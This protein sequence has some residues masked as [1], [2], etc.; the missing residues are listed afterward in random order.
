MTTEAAAQLYEAQHL[1][2]NMDRTAAVYNPNNMS[3][4]DL[5]VI[6]G[7]NNG[8]SHG[9]YEAVLLA[10]DGTFMGDHI[11]TSEAYMPFDLGILTGTRS[12]RHVDFQAHYPAGYRMEFVPG[13]RIKAHPG[14][15]AAI[16][17]NKKVTENEKGA[18]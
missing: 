8:G 4:A 12:D 13:K 2:A 18:A 11:C 16:E 17:R 15:M 1:A 6:Y 3:M 9:W 10:E 14:L 7:F 5:P